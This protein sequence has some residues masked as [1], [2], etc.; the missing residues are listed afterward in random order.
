[1]SD[2]MVPMTG[3]PAGALATLADSA[4]A[5]SE[6][7]KAAATLRGYR[8]DWR[9]F[10]AWCAERGFD[11]LP[12][13]PETVALYISDLA[14][15]RATATIARHLTA[16]AEAHKRMGHESPTAHPAVREVHRGIRRTFGTAHNHKQALETHDVRAMV[17]HL[18][19]RPMDVRDRAL[20]LIAFM[21]ALRRSE[22]VALNVD[23]VAFVP[24]GLEITVRRSKTDQEGVGEVLGVPYASDPTCCPVRALRAHL[25]SSGI[26]EGAIFRS[27]RHGERLSGRAAAARIKRLAAKIGHDPERVGGHSTRRGFITSAAKAQVHERDIMRHSRH[28]SIVVFRSYIEQANLWTDNAAVSVGL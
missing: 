18:A 25:D 26:V 10:T 21:A 3:A 7:A 27:M 4:R 13:G 22:L 16:I 8:S 28:C 19:G 1:M 6:S 9:G 24:E 11:P 17:R 2:V 23:D 15:V 12:A 20:V 5:Y 14:G